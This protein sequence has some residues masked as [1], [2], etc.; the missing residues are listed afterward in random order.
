M[1]TNNVAPT[2]ITSST[3]GTSKI[4]GKVSSEALIPVL[5][6]KIKVKVPPSITGTN[7]LPTQAQMRQA[8]ID[9]CAAD[10]ITVTSVSVK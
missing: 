10:G 6:Y 3:S 7:P 2:S 4:G 5:T 8:V 1:S 9:G